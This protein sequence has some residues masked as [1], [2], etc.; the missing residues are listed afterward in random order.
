MITK[1]KLLSWHCHFTLLR[2]SYFNFQFFPK[3]Y[4]II[5]KPHQNDRRWNQHPASF[6]FNCNLKLVMILNY[7]HN[8]RTSSSEYSQLFFK[9]VCFPVSSQHLGL[10]FDAISAAE[11][12][13]HYWTGFA[14]LQFLPFFKNM[15]ASHNSS[16]FSS[17]HIF[18]WLMDKFDTFP[19]PKNHRD[20][21][22]NAPLCMILHVK[23]PEQA[24]AG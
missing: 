20:L 7:S 5:C 9:M 13:W 17:K 2:F 1:P 10:M 6:S 22:S 23:S 3:L 18:S 19:I 12:L 24:T 11:G 21:F 15:K 14:F 4:I 8:P 16:V